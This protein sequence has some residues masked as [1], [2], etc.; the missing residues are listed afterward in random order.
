MMIMEQQPSVF[1][2]IYNLCYI[3]CELYDVV[4]GSFLMGKYQMKL[5]LDFLF[6]NS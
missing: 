4:A 5:F 2:I 3:L 6:L 1:F